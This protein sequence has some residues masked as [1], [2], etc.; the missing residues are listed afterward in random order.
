MTPLVVQTSYAEKIAFGIDFSTVLSTIETL[1]A[2]TVTWQDEN[3]NDATAMQ[4]GSA[5][6]S[7][8]GVTALVTKGSNRGTKGLNYHVSFVVTTSTGR[9][10]GG[11]KHGTIQLEIAE[12][13]Q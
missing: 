3:N 12:D 11:D 7:S 8:D 1:S 4:D 6:I 2:V 5:S 9:I 10:L 13:D